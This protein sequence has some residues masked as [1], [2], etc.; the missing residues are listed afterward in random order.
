MPSYVYERNSKEI[1]ECKTCGKGVF[2][3]AQS[4]K[5]MALTNCPSCDAP[6]HRIITKVNILGGKSY[7][8]SKAKAAGMKVLKRR[9]KGVYEEI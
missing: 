3:C 7:S 1:S 5:D 4:I 8:H 2:E 9:D 6:C